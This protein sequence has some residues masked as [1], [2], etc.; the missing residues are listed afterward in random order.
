MQPAA[1]GAVAA[2][3]AFA[4][5]ATFYAGYLTAR[6]HALEQWR[7][8]LRADFA[9]LMAAVQEVKAAVGARRG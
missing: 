2:L 5:T 6:V 8:E 3:T 1:W 7:L 4:L 9:V